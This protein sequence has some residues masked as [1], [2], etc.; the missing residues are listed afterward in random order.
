[1]QSGLVVAEFAEGACDTLKFDMTLRYS[2]SSRVYDFS[3]SIRVEPP[4]ENGGVRRIFAPVYAHPIPSTGMDGVFA[5]SAIDVPAASA[6]CVTGL[7]RVRNVAG[8]P[9][10]I[11]VNLPN[12]WEEATPYHTIAGLE[13]RRSGETSPE[14]Y[15][16]PPGLEVGRSV[17]TQAIVPITE[18]D[19]ESRSHTLTVTPSSWKV[20]GAGGVGGRGPFLYLAEMKPRD[21][22]AGEIVLAR[23]RLEK[24]GLSL[25]L[26]ENGQ[27]VVRVPVVTPGEFVIVIRAPRD[28]RFSLIVA[29]NVTGWSLD[30]RLTIDLL[31]WARGT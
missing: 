30:N 21:T 23:G 10:L 4:L 1:M 18:A 8:L 5:L 7:Y 16:F 27:W 22:R 3:R 13:R 14:L 15:T 25:G 20:S 26:V 29:N 28:G 6:G 2:A 17:I 19:I 11:D 9:V 12:R 24:G 31:G